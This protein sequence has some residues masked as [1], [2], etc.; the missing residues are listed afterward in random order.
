MNETIRRAKSLLDKK[1]AEETSLLSR[2]R[3]KTDQSSVDDFFSGL[4]EGAFL[5]AAA[6]GELS[7]EEE[8]T[9]SETLH[10][11]TGDL[12]EPEEFVEMLHAFE[13]ALE[14]DGRKERLEALALSLPDEAAR[15]AV[16]SFA[17]LVALCDRVLADAEWSALVE[18]GAIF[19]IRKED[20][21][22]LVNEV[23]VEF[24]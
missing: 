15:H 16:L 22:A 17:V 20:V 6:D 24:S 23:K 4:V 14:V 19:A 1:L 9:L 12:Y 21:E 13:E 11:I 3:R 18:M 8:L 2:F 7:E 5:L 10:G